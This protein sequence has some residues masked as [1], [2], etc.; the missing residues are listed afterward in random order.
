YYAA[1]TGTIMM[2]HYTVIGYG[3]RIKTPVRMYVDP[4]LPIGRR[5]IKWGIIIQKDKEVH[6][7]HIQPISARD[8]IMYPKSV[9]H[10][11]R[12]PRCYHYF[13]ILRLHQYI[14]NNY[15]AIIRGIKILCID[16]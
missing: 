3:N 5:K 1:I 7:L 4:H 6:S 16:I 2:S 11:V 10:T 9:P 14:F 12:L 13:Y 8:K 15:K